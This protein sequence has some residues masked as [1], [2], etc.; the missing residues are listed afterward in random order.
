MIEQ[1]NRER[2]IFLA[3]VERHA[4]DRWPAFL[5]E[6]CG[7][8]PEL[9][10]RVERLLRAHARLGSFE[11]VAKQVLIPTI[12]DPLTE[13]PGTI[14]GPYKLMEQIGEG[15]MGLVFV[16]EQQQPLRRRV[17]LKVIK[18]GMD[19]RA[20]IARFEGER[21]A[22]ALMDHENIAKVLD[23]GATASGRPYFV[24]ELVKGTP[25][26]E[27][28]DQ[29]RLALRERLALFADV[30]AAVQHA[31]QKGI[32]HRDIK[33]SNVLVTS[34]DGTPVVKVIDFGVAKA[35]GQHLTDKT[36]YTQFTQLIGTPLYMSP[37]QA[38]QS[39]LDI[40]TRTD[41]YALGVLLYELLT[42][43]TPFDRERMREAS[44]EEMRRIIREEEP[45]KPSTRIST[46]GK[47]ASTVSQQR[48]S[49]PRQLTY[50]FRGELDWIVMKAMEKDRKRR[51]ETAS[52]FAGDVRHYL[53]DEPVMACPPSAAYRF[54]KF[55][56]RNRVALTLASVVAAALVVVLTGLAVGMILLGR[57]NT[58]LEA[59]IHETR[60][61]SGLAE[62]NFRKAQ[63]A[64]DGYFTQVS[65]NRLL[66]SPVPGL[67]PL[68][69]ELLETALNYY[70]AFIAEHPEESALRSELARAYFRVAVI[71]EEI[72]T[73]AEALQAYQAS[74]GLWEQ[75][76]QDDPGNSQVRSHLAE[77]L[78]RIGS[79]Q[80]R[81]LGQP[82]EGF[83]ALH[84]A[85]VI[86]EELCRDEPASVEFHSGLAQT[87]FILG[88]A[89][90][91]R[92]KASDEL[93]WYEKALEIWQPLAEADPKF[94][95]ELGTTA[96]SIGYYY[97][98]AGKPTEALAFFEQ[99]RK[100][101]VQLCRDHPRDTALL[102]EL[103]R[104]YINI[105]YVHHSLT[106]QY[107]DALRAY[108]QSRLIVEQLTRENPAVTDFQ[109]F[110]AGI[111]KQMGE[112]QSELKHFAQA[113]EYH[114]QAA[115]ILDQL[116]QADPSNTQLLHWQGG[117][118]VQLARAQA[119]LDRS[120][121]FEQALASCQKAQRIF[122]ELLRSDPN[123]V[124]YTMERSECYEVAALL[125]RK[126]GLRE[127]AI[128]SYQQAIDLLENIPENPRAE[129]ER[130]PKD[131]ITCYTALGDVQRATGQRVGAEHS[132]RQV[133]QIR[134][135]Y[136]DG[137]E[138]RCRTLSNFYPAWSSLSQLQLD[139]G[140]RKEA[141]RTLEQARML[142]EKILQ[143]RGEDLYRLACLQA[144]LSGLV[145]SGQTALTAPQQAERLRYQDQ[146]ME[147]LR[148][149][150]AAGYHD[151]AEL[152]QDT[153]LDSLRSRQDFQKLLA[154]LE[155]QAAERRSRELEASQKQR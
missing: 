31:H 19:S 22:L 90:A 139:G 111:Y 124:E 119:Q 13:R 92:Q 93:H 152:K 26:T 65:E 137:A 87:C 55:A 45:P 34:H 6:A 20:V 53:H 33:P 4:P 25:I 95:S 3:A 120:D 133:L 123:Q 91:T 41:I 122:Q 115:A 66:K 128:H 71:K 32:I 63:Q 147:A 62:A 94:R 11:E 18:P 54:R 46:L 112:V 7:D 28:C 70:Q 69:K 44:Y 117:S 82:I 15:G 76:V 81:F 99:A 88:L 102:V 140:K 101:F 17:A 142:F 106:G 145:G 73:K 113:E 149:A 79:V 143:P 85:R 83:A 109:G 121:R 108:D 97:T 57:A 132:Y 61:Q 134:E 67:Q 138:R 16:A 10:L 30:C 105:G 49:D 146:A 141:R 9:R 59:Q 52:A 23:A 47:A 56:R 36:V 58:L 104:V 107:Q 24:M 72:A 21:Q 43:T 42:G 29:N 37:E 2:S 8:D 126:M 48:Q 155:D 96:I 89:E 110:K 77:C 103:R 98:R 136:F 74:R 100:I 153:G 12:D 114:R 131:L 130:I 80:S 35:I 50:L 86:Y 118:H 78:R 51:Y 68:R 40:D 135:R 75:L 64:V 125:Y 150:I 151:P 129:N 127:E 116:T 148:K 1:S 60:R 14:I 84:Q 144:R 5:D 154:G 38:G 39:S 27:Y